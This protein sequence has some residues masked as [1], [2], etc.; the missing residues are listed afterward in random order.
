M[1]SD[2]FSAID[3]LTNLDFVISNPPYI[4]SNKISKLQKEVSQFEPRKALDGGKDGLF[5][6]RYLLNVANNMLKKNGEMILEIGFDQQN[7]LTKLKSRFPAW[8]STNFINDLQD[9]VRV[10]ILGK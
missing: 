10:W 1:R 7:A 9:N 6:Y 8:R 2:L 3:Y 5:F 4:P